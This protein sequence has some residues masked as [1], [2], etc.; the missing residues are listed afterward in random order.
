MSPFAGEGA[1][2][3]M[4]DG[5]V[6]AGKIADALSLATDNSTRETL[7]SAIASYEQEMFVLSKQIAQAS[8]DNLKAMISERGL[9]GAIEYIETAMKGE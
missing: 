2:L 7:E 6:L 3:A 9:Q 5:A 1:N 8:D 4:Y